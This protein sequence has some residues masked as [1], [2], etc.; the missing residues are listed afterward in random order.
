MFKCTY[1]L[2][3][4]YILVKLE[5]RKAGKLSNKSPKNKVYLIKINFEKKPG[6]LLVLR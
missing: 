5:M 4:D 3:R 1:S 2:H 6:L